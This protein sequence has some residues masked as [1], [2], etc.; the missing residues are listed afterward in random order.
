M[1]EVAPLLGD[2]IW[3]ALSPLV[4]QSARRR[5]L[6]AQVQRSDASDRIVRYA[7]ATGPPAA[8]LSPIQLQVLLQ[9]FPRCQPGHCGRA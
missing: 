7:V 4:Y 3:M 8:P 9:Q 1:G 6:F 2:A 5:Q